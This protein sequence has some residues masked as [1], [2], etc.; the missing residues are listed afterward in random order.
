MDKIKQLPDLL[1]QVDRIASIKNE[2]K[3]LQMEYH[4]YITPTISDT[5]LLPVLFEWYKDFSPDSGKTSRDGKA[6]FSQCFIF[7]ITL[8][9]SPST[10]TGGKLPF[11]L[12]SQLSQIFQYKSPTSISNIIPNLMF[13]YRTYSDFK[14]KVETIF[15]QMIIKLQ[16]L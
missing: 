2:F 16:D 14:S 15:N 9:Y 13:L 4:H 11:G 6:A 12:R 3:K 8:L 1:E 7:I 10:L 5:S